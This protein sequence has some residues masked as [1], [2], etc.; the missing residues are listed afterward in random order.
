MPKGDASQADDVGQENASGKRNEDPLPVEAKSKS[1]A[2][3]V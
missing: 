3:R 2:A 1:D